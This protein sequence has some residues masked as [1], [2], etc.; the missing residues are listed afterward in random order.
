MSEMIV[1]KLTGKTSAGDI[2]VVSEGGAATMQ[3]QQGLC[4]AWVNLDGTPGTVLVR[5]SF[6]TASITDSGTGNYLLNFS[7]IM[8]NDD[9]AGH[10]YHSSTTGSGMNVFNNAWGGGHSES[11]TQF[12]HSSYNGTF[13]DSDFVFLTVHGDLA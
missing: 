8:R 11:T 5:D 7:S 4:K 13:V 10:N 3:L 2:D 12:G 9:Y 6:N 1:N